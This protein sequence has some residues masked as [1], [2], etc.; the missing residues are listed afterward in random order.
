[1]LQTKN[2][3][4]GNYNRDQTKVKCF[5]TFIVRSLIFSLLSLSSEQQVQANMTLI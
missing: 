5:H 2:Q 1:M 3:I 4:K